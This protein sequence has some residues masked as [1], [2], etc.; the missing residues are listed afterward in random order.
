MSDRVLYVRP[1]QTLEECMAL[2]TQ[3]RVRHL[4]V[5]DGSKLTGLISIGDVVKEMIADRDLEIEELENYVSGRG[6]VADALKH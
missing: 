1:E 2:M 3:N 4:P 5:L 6:Y